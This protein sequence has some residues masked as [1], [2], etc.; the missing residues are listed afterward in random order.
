MSGD[1]TKM[2]VLQTPRRD[3]IALFEIHYWPSHKVSSS[4][5]KIK[6]FSVAQDI[7]RL[8]PKLEY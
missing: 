7:S 4:T 6:N 1:V 5:Q 2:A 3:I 8:L